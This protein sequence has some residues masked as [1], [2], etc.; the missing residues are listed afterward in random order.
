MNVSS[1][2][3]K[4]SKLTLSTRVTGEKKL[5]VVDGKKYPACHFTTLYGEPVTYGELAKAWR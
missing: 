2:V 3:V 1:V 4:K 5:V